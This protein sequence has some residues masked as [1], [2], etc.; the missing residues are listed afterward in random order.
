MADLGIEEFRR[1]VEEERQVLPHDDRWTAFLETLPHY[2]ET[3]RRPAT[4]LNGQARSGDFNDW[5]ATNVYQQRQEGYA[6]VTVNLPLGD[7]T[8]RQSFQLADIARKYVGDSVRTTVE[9][10][11][12]LRW[13]PQAD[14]PALYADLK[15][16]G[17][18]A[19]GAG[20]I[21]D[22][23]SCPGTDTCKLGIASSRGLAAE[24]STRLAEK[25]HTLDTAVQGL[26]WCAVHR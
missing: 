23:T 5:Y 19:A 20:T 18:G 9:Q 10:N 14:L 3:P 1:L 8:T 25:A 15:A 21:V 17:L 26:H 22:I 11:I 24:L 7:I 6:V 4:H 2:K 12:V 16:I 13:V